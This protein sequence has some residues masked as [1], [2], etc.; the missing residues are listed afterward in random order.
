LEKLMTNDVERKAALKR[1]SDDYMRLAREKAA[2]GLEREAAATAYEAGY[3]AL[4]TAL[5]AAEVQ[6]FSD[7]PNATAAELAVARL[8]TTA[9]VRRLAIEGATAFYAPKTDGLVGSSW[10]DWAQHLRRIAG[11]GN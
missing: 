11:I 1:Q 7:H 5:T 3:F 6:G 4:M 9:T 10:V 8:G 2:V